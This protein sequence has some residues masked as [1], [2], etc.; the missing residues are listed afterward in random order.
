MSRHLRSFGLGLFSLALLAGSNMTTLV[1][2]AVPA[3]DAR[4]PRAKAP[5]LPR[6]TSVDQLV[7]F[8]RIILQRDYIGQRLGWSI[9][10][11]EKV[12][13][14]ISTHTHPWVTEAFYR[15]L[16]DLNCVA[17][18][19]MTD[20]VHY[21]EK[22]WAAQ[23]TRLM[24]RRLSKDLNVAPPPEERVG[25]GGSGIPRPRR[26]GLMYTEKELNNYDVIIG[27]LGRVPGLAGSIN[28]AAPQEL[29]SAAEIF[30]GELGDKIDE[31]AWQVIRNADKVFI[32]DLQGS[33]AEFTWFPEWWEIVEGTHPTIR[34]PADM[35]TFNA[36]R[37]GR[38]EFAVFAGHLMGHP[39]E[40]AIRGT[41]FRGKL[42]GTVGDFGPMPKMTI[43]H[44]RGEITKI[45]GGS[46]Y[47]KMW[48]D[49]LRLT[50][51]ILYPGYSRPGTGW[52][53]EFSLG[54]NPKFLG[55]TEIDEL[56][57]KDRADLAQMD[58]GRSRDRAGLYHAGYG[59]RGVS[60]WA[61]DVDVPVNYY[62]LFLYFVTYEVLTRDG[63]RVKLVDK[64]HLNILDDP[65]IRSLAAKY[66]DPDKLLST[67]WIPEI[68]ADGTLKAPK[69]ELIPY[70]EWIASLPMKL[71]DPRIVYRIPEKLK[72][73]YGED[74]VRYYDKNEFLEFYKK[75]GTIPVKRV[76]KQG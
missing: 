49:H 46:Y 32:T 26:P 17:D 18:V 27:P 2:R 73:F 10:G 25:F 74:R 36:L 43:S 61:Q 51:D 4:A 41:D 69:S 15:A 22:E 39:R 62:H 50:E 54:T 24:E 47:G 13:L 71:D 44:D 76:K 38:S 3:D 37:P 67:D 65:E 59:S 8:A 33:S 1:S 60:W 52:M 9:K 30:P 12:L 53:G 68:A 75:Q 63:K 64:G 6:I 19:V 70:D 55:P 56:K 48:S 40:A 28:W 31:K 72:K 29:A 21:D 23:L 57:G 35:S 14:Q 7:P 66:G 58:W 34:S 42:A 5:K 11:G 20:S 45:E 16:K